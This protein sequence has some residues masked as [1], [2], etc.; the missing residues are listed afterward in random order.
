MRTLIRTDGIPARERFGRW[1][2]VILG[3]P[4]PVN[5]RIRYPG[6]FNAELQTGDLALVNILSICSQ[7]SYEFERTPELIRRS[8]PEGYRLIVASK[9]ESGIVAGDDEVALHDND[10]LLLDT[11]RPF[12]GWRGAHDETVQWTLLTVPRDMVPIPRKTVTGLVGTRLT[13]RTE[14]SE[15]VHRFLR[16]IVQDLDQFSE[17]DRTRLAFTIADLLAVLI[18]HELEAGHSAPPESYR[19]VLILRINDFIQRHLSDPRLGPQMVA[20]ANQISIRQLHK[21]FSNQDHTVAE[22]IRLR[23]LEA[24]LRDLADP[25][26]QEAPVY[27]IG[28]RYGFSSAAHF[29]RV[30]RGHFGVT[31]QEYRNKMVS[32]HHLNR[33]AGSVTGASDKPGSGNGE[34][35]LFGDGASWGLAGGEQLQFGG[36]ALA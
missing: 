6:R 5:V 29:S 24:C 33:L 7:G 10:L 12:R 31:P 21:L 19:T 30:F 20:A 13:S 2:D 36:D 17:Q 34:E 22:W 26:L 3:L 25:L 16:Q 28:I 27:A 4:A 11:S 18:A 1:R 8:D 32:A 15:L 9:G 23:R 35:G 14:V